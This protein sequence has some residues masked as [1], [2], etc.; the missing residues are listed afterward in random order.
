MLPGWLGL[1]TAYEGFLAAYPGGRDAGLALLREMADT[2]PFWRTVLSN[3]VSG[4]KP[5]WSGT[6]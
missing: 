5:E 4:C 6:G 3:C 2:W 1:G